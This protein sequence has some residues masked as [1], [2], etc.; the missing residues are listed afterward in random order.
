METPF[1]W[2]SV[3]RRRSGVWAASPVL[4]FPELDS[5]NTMA[6]SLIPDRAIPGTVVVADFQRAGR[7][8]LARRWTAAPRSALMITV[9]LGPHEPRWS[10]PMLSGL[11]VLHA[12]SRLGLPSTLKWPNDVLIAGRKCCGILIESRP[13]DDGAVW[14]LAGIGINVRSVDPD[15]HSAT[16]LDAHAAAPVS[17][18]DLLVEVLAQIAHWRE[19]AMRDAI[20]L[21]ERWTTSLITIG[22]L[23]TVQTAAGPLEGLASGV[24]QDGGLIVQTVTGARVVQAGDVTLSSGR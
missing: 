5:T 4:Y 17:R 9:V 22:Q 13:V 2:R 1:D 12:L 23:V 14:L 15:L 6:A 10:A 11:A 20:S 7:G 19:E 8:R 24:A 16:Y 3:A 18:E 21:R